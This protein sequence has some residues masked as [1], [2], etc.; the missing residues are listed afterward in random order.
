MNRWVL[1]ACL[2]AV[3]SAPCVKAAPPPAA[4]APP[5]EKPE[6]HRFEPVK[7]EATSS[8]GSVSIDGKTVSYQAIAGTLVI[9]PKDWD[10]VPRDPAEDM[11]GLVGGVGLF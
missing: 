5:G 8:N 6:P 4:A 2:I 10:D 1:G 7:S 3:S 9:H 11:L